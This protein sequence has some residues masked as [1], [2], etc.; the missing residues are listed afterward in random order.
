MYLETKTKFYEIVQIQNRVYIHYGKIQSFNKQLPFGISIYYEF[1]NNL[2]AKNFYEKKLKEKF[3][4]NY[5]IIKNKKTEDFKW[6]YKN[7]KFINKS[8]NKSIKK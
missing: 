6:L 5:E 3:N 1:K 2:E 4:R 7:H 8:L